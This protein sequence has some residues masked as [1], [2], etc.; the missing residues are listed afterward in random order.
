MACTQIKISEKFQSIPILSGNLENIKEPL[1]IPADRPSNF[2]Y[3][4]F[5]IQFCSSFCK[6]GFETIKVHRFLCKG[7]F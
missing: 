1:F 3:F 4:Y 6:V 7:K 2:N 5:V